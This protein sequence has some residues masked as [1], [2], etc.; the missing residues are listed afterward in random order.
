[1]MNPH[2]SS[3]TTQPVPRLSGDPFIWY[4]I[5]LEGSTFS[6]LFVVFAFVRR[7]NLE[8]FTASQRLLDVSAGALNTLLLLTA[9]WCVVRA[10][11]VVRAN[12]RGTAFGWLGAGIACGIGFVAL[13]WMEYADKVAQGIELSTNL[14][15]D[16]YFLLTGFHLLHVLAG[17]LA[18]S[19][20]GI[21]LVL[22][23]RPLNAHTIET[24]A[25]FWHLV[26]LLWL[27]L[28]PLLYLLR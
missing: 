11:H 12:R 13:K 3:I 19:M 9:S 4:I 14:F 20:T 22:Q 16:F 5:L 24:A 10:V 7:Q 25:A 6:L 28:F 2:H 23:Q 15:F 21:G 8:L 26:D 18:L 1:M 17:L 27:V